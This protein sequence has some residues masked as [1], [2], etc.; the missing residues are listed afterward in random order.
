MLVTVV[1]PI[2]DV[3]REITLATLWRPEIAVVAILC[4]TRRF[5][6]H[7]KMPVCRNA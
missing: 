5:D 3:L 7:L 2:A 6:A 4:S 1:V